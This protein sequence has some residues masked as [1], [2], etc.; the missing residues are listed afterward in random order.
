MTP[1][2]KVKWLVLAYLASCD[3]LPVPAYPCDN[4]DELFDAA[5]KDHV[6]DCQCEVR[7]GQYETGLEP[8]W[9]SHYE[10]KA[11]AARLPDGSFVGWTYWYGGGKHG[12]PG[13]LEWMENAYEV[14]CTEEQKMVTVRTFTKAK[15]E[16]V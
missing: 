2:Q 9:S 4:V 13:S 16:G 11:V 5:D 7:S 12:D 6:Y 3:D 8:E 1:E 10:S 15:S 14:N